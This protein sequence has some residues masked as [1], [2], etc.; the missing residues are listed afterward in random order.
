MELHRLVDTQKYPRVSYFFEHFL[1]MQFADLRCLLQ[2]PKGDLNAGCNYAAASVLFNMI[3]G[4]SVCLFNASF[5]HF[6]SSNPK[7]QGKRFTDLLISYYPWQSEP[8]QKDTAVRV[9]YHSLRNPL[10]HCLGLYR[11]GE[12]YSS[13]IEKNP[14]DL[15]QISELE[16]SKTRPNWL[17]PTIRLSQSVYHFDVNIDT[18]Y[19]GVNRLIENLLNDKQQVKTAEAFLLQLYTE[20]EISGFK[21][22]IVYLESLGKSAPQYSDMTKAM[23]RRLAELLQ[24]KDR[25]TPNQNESLQQLWKDYAVFG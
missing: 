14:L 20:Y 22:N 16:S 1:T 18:L 4:L 11:P 8:V 13:N 9:L 3:S 17:N 19:W 7:G 10:T 6:M 24:Q 15:K 25:L 5:D 2:L 12:K 23:K 21:T